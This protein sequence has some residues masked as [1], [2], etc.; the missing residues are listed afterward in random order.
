MRRRP[1]P[2]AL[3][4]LAAFATGACGTTRVVTDKNPAAST[5]TTGKPTKS[6]TATATAPT[7][8]TAI[9]PGPPRCTAA[10]LKLSYL[11]GQ[12]ATGHGALGFALT[13]TRAGKCHTYGYPGIQFLSAS[14]TPLP[15]RA[16]RTTRDFFGSAPAV[17]LTLK[18]GVSASFRLGVTHQGAGGATSRC[19][20]A[21]ALGAI[22]P[23]DT[24]TLRVRI[25]NG[26]AYECGTATVTP[27]RPGHS[28]FP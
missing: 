27:L 2:F 9:A 12:G 21:A 26:G 22:A 7:P 17:A 20:T 11:G 6:S 10:N 23:D 28:A 4:A 15:T 24:R 25:G 13:N 5:A 16:V 8:S 18:P 14:G 19:T 1:L 3:L